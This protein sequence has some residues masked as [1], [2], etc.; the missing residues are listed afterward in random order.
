MCVVVNVLSMCCCQCVVVSVLLSVSCCQCVVV[1]VLLSMCCCQCVVN[2]L[3]VCC[4]RVVTRVLEFCC[5]HVV[6][7]MLLFSALLLPVC[8][9][10]VLFSLCDCQRA[11]SVFYCNRVDVRCCCYAGVSGWPVVPEG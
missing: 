4:K 9:V 10:N 8:F 7:S 3:S 5:Q 11:L 6:I 2:V 1:S